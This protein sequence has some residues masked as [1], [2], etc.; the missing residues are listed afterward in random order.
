MNV[1]RKTYNAKKYRRK[2]SIKNSHRSTKRSKKT[3]KRRR[4]SKIRYNRKTRKTRKK[5]GTTPPV[6]PLELQGAARGVVSSEADKGPFIPLGDVQGDW[7]VGPEGWGHPTTISGGKLAFDALQK[8]KLRRIE[9]EQLDLERKRHLRRKAVGAPP[10]LTMYEKLAQEEKAKRRAIY[11][12]NIA[13][14]AAERAMGEE[15]RLRATGKYNE[16]E[17]QTQLGA[18]GDGGSTKASG[19]ASGGAPDKAPTE[20]V[21]TEAYG[22]AS[23][24]EE[25]RLAAQR[26]RE[27]QRVAAEADQLQAREVAEQD[28]N[29]SKVRQWMWGDAG[30]SAKQRQIAEQSDPFKIRWENGTA[31]ELHSKILAFRDKKKLGPGKNSERPINIRDVTPDNSKGWIRFANMDSALLWLNHVMTHGVERHA[32]DVLGVTRPWN[33]TADEA[34]GWLT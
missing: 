29:K 33:V 8:E 21:F 19:G 23:S 26:D 34:R 4:R 32:G 12:T 15:M 5:G 22:G 9:S 7:A 28:M 6:A 14:A 18:P 25:Q 27:A 2:R 10:S 31:A 20:E 1:R 24:A 11:E 16:G 30:T 13:A 17:I 3:M